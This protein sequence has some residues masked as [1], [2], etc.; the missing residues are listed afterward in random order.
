[1]D[2]Q[3]IAAQERGP[4]VAVLGVGD[5][6]ADRLRVA[7]VLREAGIAVRADGSARKLGKQLEG[8]AKAG[9]TWAVI[10]GEELADGNV[11]LKDLG[12]GDQRL[13]A[14]GDVAPTVARA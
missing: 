6:H 5:D 14:L 9:A 1:M 10:V 8:A 3:G 4:L 12:S 13:V 7:S 11:S 2:E